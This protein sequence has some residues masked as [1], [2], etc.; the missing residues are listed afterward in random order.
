MSARPLLA[1]FVGGKSRQMGEHEGLLSVRGSTEPIPTVVA[2][3]RTE[4]APWEPMLARYDARRLAHTVADALSR[5]EKS[6]QELFASVEVD[7]LSFSAAVERALED[8]D[9]PSD[10]D[11]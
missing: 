4:D 11:R 3:T 6:F 2:P 1:I 7:M 5:G 10:V 8:W 9:S